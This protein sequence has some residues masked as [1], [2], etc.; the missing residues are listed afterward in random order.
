MAEAVQE[1]TPSADPMV[2]PGPRKSIAASLT[3]L[4]AGVLAFFMGMT[5]VF[6]VE[7][8]AWIFVLWGGLLFYNNLVD[9][10]LTYEVTE[11][12]LV[13]KSPLRF[14]GFKR[15]WPWQNINRLDLV[16]NRVEAEPEDVEMQIYYTPEESTVIA[17]EDAPYYP[18]LAQLI[19][20]RSQLKAEGGQAMQDFSAIPQNEK[21][22]YSWKK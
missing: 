18:N 8:M 6:F 17:R 22:T 9:L 4:I 1:Q 10:A 2:F 11:E 5:H 12:A 21:A 14:W 16:V 7:A 15:V 3:L 20:E 13:I 19:V